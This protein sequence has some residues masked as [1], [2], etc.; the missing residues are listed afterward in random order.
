MAG[1]KGKILFD[2]VSKL[3]D[4]FAGKL[5]NKVTMDFEV[6]DDNYA[7]PH[8]RLVLVRENNSGEIVYLT[9]LSVEGENH[10]GGF[11]DDSKT[12][13]SFNITRYFFQLLNNPEY[14]DKLYL[15]ADFPAEN[16]NRTILNNTK[17]SINV[18]YSEI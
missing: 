16:A 4:M 13:Y 15:R 18:I 8:N 17:I 6:I 9:D 12:F 7:D 1:H 5:L 10:F 2:S 3:Q 11:L 14:T